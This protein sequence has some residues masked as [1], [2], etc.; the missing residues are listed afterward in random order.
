M[1]L[2]Q[3]GL[4]GKTKVAAR[5]LVTVGAAATILGIALIPL[6]PSSGYSESQISATAAYTIFI[7]SLSFPGVLNIIAGIMFIKRKPGARKLAVALL[8][9]ECCLSLAATIAVAVSEGL[10]I[11]MTFIITLILCVIPLLLLILDRDKTKNNQSFM[12][13]Q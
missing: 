13:G 4:Q 6:N 10:P 5:W 3:I 11:A 7:L 8:S 12:K 9:A 2:K 1:S